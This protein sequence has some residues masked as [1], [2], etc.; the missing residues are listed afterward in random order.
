[1]TNDSYG[2]I[3]GLKDTTSQ[4]H[5]DDLAL[6]DDKGLLLGIERASKTSPN[7]PSR[8]LVAGIALILMVAGVFFSF[9][10]SNVTPNEGTTMT[11]QKAGTTNNLGSLFASVEEPP[12]S[13]CLPLAFPCTRRCCPGLYCA[14]T[15]GG[16]KICVRKKILVPGHQ[17][18]KLTGDDPEVDYCFE[19]PAEGAIGEPNQT[20]SWECFEEDKP[21]PGSDVRCFNDKCNATNKPCCDGSVCSV[22][23]HCDLR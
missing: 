5:G 3:E 11:A 4:H 18:V 19:C 13:L 10:N 8:F 7:Q 16:G 12:H 20:R 15:G 2:A 6:P 23:G 17:C 1:M 9:S 21:Y 14:S 22:D